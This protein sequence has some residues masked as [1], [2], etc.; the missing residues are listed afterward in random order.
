M[1]NSNRKSSLSSGILLFT[2][3]SIF[4]AI[5]VALIVITIKGIIE[6]GLSMIGVGIVMPIIFI[7]AF[8]GFGITALTMGGKQIYFRIRQRITYNQGKEIIAQIVDYKSA[9]FSK[10]H[11]LRK[12]YALILEYKEDGENKTFT[13]DYLYDVNEFRYLK[14]LDSIKVKVD[15]NF[16]TVCES[17]PKD[18]YKVDST[19]GIEVEFFKQKPVTVLI[20]L[21]MIFFIV[22][23]MFLIISFFVRNSTVTSVAIISLFSVHFPFAI[24]LAIY[25]IKWFN[26]NK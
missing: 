12:R 15:S 19:Y 6:Y 22:A 17:F 4:T 14:E 20:R 16:V 7:L 2:V 1:K 26:R 23:F 25:L 8:F 21:W 5:G 24:A 18:I 10:G 13:T 3:G 11:N 9:S